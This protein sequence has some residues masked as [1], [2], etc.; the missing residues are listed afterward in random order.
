MYKPKAQVVGDE[1]LKEFPD[2]EV[3]LEVGSSGQFDVIFES[4]PPALLFSKSVQ[5]PPRFPYDGEIVGK[6][7]QEK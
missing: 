6:L 5:R 3:I 2:A 4:D 1:I 7:K